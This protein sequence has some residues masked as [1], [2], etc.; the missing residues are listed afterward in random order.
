MRAD[1]NRRQEF[2]ILP[3]LAT[4]AFLLKK[5]DVAKQH[6]VELESLMP[7][8]AADAKEKRADWYFGRNS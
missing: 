8:Y 6:V 5:Y 4:Y 2:D 7:G 1:G 3:R